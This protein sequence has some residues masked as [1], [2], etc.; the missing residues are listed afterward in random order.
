MAYSWR[1]IIAFATWTTG[2]WLAALA[3]RSRGRIE[4]LYA[5]LDGRLG[6]NEFIAGPRFSIVDITALVTIDFATRF[7]LEMAADQ[8][9]L[10]RWYDQINARPSAQA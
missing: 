10:K 5:I 3:E 6:E 7:E 2:L 4:R 1:T 8:A 9:H